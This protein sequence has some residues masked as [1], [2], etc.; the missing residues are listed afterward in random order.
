M[1]RSSAE[2]AALA[3]PSKM[4]FPESV[5]GSHPRLR[6]SSQGPRL[7]RPG[8]KQA[9]R[10]FRAREQGTTVLHVREVATNPQ[11]CIKWSHYI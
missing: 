7:E 11:P 10:D 8:L 5:D 6:A 2:E 3:T 9:S 4:P 1:H